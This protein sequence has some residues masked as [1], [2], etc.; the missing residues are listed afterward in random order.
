MGNKMR[1]KFDHWFAVLDYNLVEMCADRA[2]DKD[3][4][5]LV[6]LNICQG[7]FFWVGDRRRI[8]PSNS[9]LMK[10][11][12][13]LKLLIG[14]IFGIGK[15]HHETMADTFGLDAADDFAKIDIGDRGK[16]PPRSHW[17]KNEPMIAPEYSE[18]TR[19]RRLRPQP[20]ESSRE[21][22]SGSCS[23]RVRRW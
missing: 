7:A 1:H 14:V 21:T 2:I 16:A 10:F 11:S 15:K 3:D 4:R 12:Y 5:N 8:M 6:P 18:H 23:E 22:P 13:D 20:R 9:S 17:S 19:S